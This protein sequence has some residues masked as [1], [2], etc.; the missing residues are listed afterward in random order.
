MLKR[1]DR[2]PSKHAGSIRIPSGSARK[3]WPEAGQMI[4]AH[5]LPS[6]PDPFGKNLTVSQNQIGSTPYDPR[7][8]CNK[9]TEFESERLAAGRFQ[10]A[11]NQAR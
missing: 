3:R 7:L 1:D 5:R 10:S 9:A 11:R 4:I 2:Y 8:L 6:G